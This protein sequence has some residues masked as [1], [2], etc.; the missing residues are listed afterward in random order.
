MGLLAQ[1]LEK[2]FP[3]CVYTNSSGIKTIDYARLIPILIADSRKQDNDIEE[4]KKM[5]NQLQNLFLQQ[6][7]LVEKSKK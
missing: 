5:V 6:Q 1:D 2:L 3:N 4:L 7:I